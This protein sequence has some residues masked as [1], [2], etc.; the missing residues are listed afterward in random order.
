M[1][2][3]AFLL[4]HPI[5]YHS[6]FFKLIDKRRDIE[7]KV[8]YCSDYGASESGFKVHPEMGKIPNWDVSLIDGYSH[9]F[10][11]NNSWKPSIFRGYFGLINF[12]LFSHLKRDKPDVLI[13]NGWSYFTMLYALIICRFLGIKSYLR[14]DN[15]IQTDGN[16]SAYKAFLKKG[17]FRFFLFKIPN[18]FLYVG[19]N[20]R[21]FFKKYKVPDKKLLWTPHAVDNER[22]SHEYLKM[23]PDEENIKEQLN[24]PLDAFI[25]L[26]VGRFIPQKSPLDLLK[27]YKNIK[28][29][30]ALIMIGDGPMK[31]EISDFIEKYNLQNVYLP[32]FIN[33]K[34]IGAY[35]T[36][37]DVFVLTSISET[38][39]LVVNEAMNFEL[40]IVVTTSTG[41]APNL[42]KPENGYVVATGDTSQMTKILQKMIDN[43]SM[44][45]KMGEASS[46]IVKEY[47]YDTVIER[48]ISYID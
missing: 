13:L 24:I 12:N 36:I 38:W 31:D 11:R 15:T 32:G 21:L 48:L 3:I 14:G 44:I 4:S 16:I 35:F 7:L 27:V 43:P 18:W 17:I 37:S 8:Y 10:L 45:E 26:F 42:V 6:P 22:F 5:Q 33:Q 30:K 19:E 1:K 34:N 2:K 23:K 25:M 39:G 40:P 20:N 47:S 9:C 29:K 28:G 46:Q 41:C